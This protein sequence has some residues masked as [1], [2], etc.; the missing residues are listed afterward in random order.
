MAA[1]SRAQKGESG[2]KGEQ[3]VAQKHS[4]PRFVTSRRPAPT[5]REQGIGQI[6]EAQVIALAET[7]NAV[8]EHP[9]GRRFFVPGA[10]IGER[11]RV[12]VKE[13][14]SQFGMGELVEILE[15]SAARVTPPCRFHGFAANQCGG[16]AWMFVDYAAQ[17]QAKQQRVEQA[18]QR[19]LPGQPVLPILPAPEP[20]G[21]RLRAQL[22]TDGKELGFVA[23]AQRQLAAVDDCLVLTPHNRDTLQALRTRLPNADWTPGRKQDWT[24]LDIDE[25]VDSWNVSVNKRLPFQQAN[26]SQNHSMKAWLHDHLNALP[27]HLPVLELFAGS[28]NFTEVIATAGFE[29]VTAVDVVVEAVAALTQRKLSGV[30][31]TA[32]D[33]FD[34]GA[35]AELMRQHRSAEILVLDPPRDGLKCRD[36]LFERKSRLRE[37]LYISCDLATFC[38]DLRDFVAAGFTLAELQPVDLFPQTPHVELLA[39]L[40]RGT[41]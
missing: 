27:R 8:V 25:S 32:C 2:E 21:Y 39:H 4:G 6:F 12:K 14:K 30:T 22:K 1:Q 35:F 10:W 29:S 33:L 28:G 20:L 40:R 36:G 15:P 41:P 19:I 37:V 18:V 31:A 38:R 11:V 9:N 16:C 7:G 24:T 17:L 5:G 34:A 3:L 26:E 13:L 23:N